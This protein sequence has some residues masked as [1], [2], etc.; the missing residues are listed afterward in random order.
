M[1]HMRRAPRL[2][3]FAR[4]L[5]PVS[6][7][8]PRG[9]AAAAA[10]KPR[11]MLVNE[12]RL[13]W[14][15]KVD[16]EP[17]RAVGTLSRNEPDVDG[18]GIVKLA[19]GQEVL[20]TKESTVDGEC[21]ASLPD[22]VK[23]ICEAGTGYNNIDLAEAKKRGITVT[24]CPEYATDGTA[25]LG[26][27]FVISFSSSLLQQQRMLSLGDRSNFQSDMMLPHFE[28]NGKVLGLIG[29]T[30]A[31]GGKAAQIAMTFGMQVLM[32]S[33]TPPLRPVNP[34]IE[35]VTLDELLSRSDFV[36][37][38]CPLNAESKHLI[39]AANLRKM[40]STAYL[41]NVARGAIV[42]EQALIEALR[43]GTIA[44]AGLDVQEQEPPADDNPLYT[45]DNV[46]ITP[47]IGWKKVESRNRLIESVARNIKAFNAGRPINVVGK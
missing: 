31:I 34:A 39:N 8:A 37:I 30:G 46:I 17:L 9:F 32:Y 40:K 15:G 10:A 2:L 25:Q 44:G 13:N 20:I 22:T 38:H 6:L 43:A 11:I 27:A 24:N 29:G 26:M 47:H 12:S 19:D 18:A 1:Y 36:S 23:L 28:L 21:I 7:G 3:G 5:A 33:R 45:M 35:N 4:G 14:D 16:L 41:I 42:D